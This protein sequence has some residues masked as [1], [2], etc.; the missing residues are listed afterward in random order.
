M[1]GERPRRGDQMRAPVT[2]VRPQAEVPDAHRLARPKPQ[3]SRQTSTETSVTGSASG[4]SGLAA[5]T[6]TAPA[7]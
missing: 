4:G 6:H 3:A 5:L 7:S 1:P 2:D